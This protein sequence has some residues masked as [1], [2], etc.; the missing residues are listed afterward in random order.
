LLL[1]ATPTQLSLIS[2]RQGYQH[3][4]RDFVRGVRHVVWDPHVIY[5]NRSPIVCSFLKVN[6]V[7]TGIG[8]DHKRTFRPYIVY[9]KFAVF[10]EFRTL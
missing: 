4:G 3:D 10:K 9:L 8:K 5:G 1:V 2:Y 6:Y 7:G